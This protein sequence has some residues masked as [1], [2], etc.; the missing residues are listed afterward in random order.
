MFA[1]YLYMLNFLDLIVGHFD[2]FSNFA[3]RIE[4]I[5]MPSS[6]RSW[7]SM[8]PRGSIFYYRSFK[9]LF[10][11]GVLTQIIIPVTIIDNQI[12]VIA[13]ASIPILL[14]LKFLQPTFTAWCI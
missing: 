14:K 3:P 10:P 7:T 2:I 5:G 12:K 8:V 1:F 9:N 13:N 6:L 4:L 11:D